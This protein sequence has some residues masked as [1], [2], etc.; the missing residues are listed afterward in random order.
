M[1]NYDLTTLCEGYAFLVKRG[2]RFF[3]MIVVL[4][5]A[6]RKI[7]SAVTRAALCAGRGTA[8]ARHPATALLLKKRRRAEYRLSR[9][10]RGRGNRGRSLTLDISFF[11]TRR[12]PFG[13]ASVKDFPQKIGGNY[14]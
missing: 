7:W 6:R 9:G 4:R 1:S 13:G 5:V 11:Q 8:F 2:M 14:I 3:D 10:N 12:H